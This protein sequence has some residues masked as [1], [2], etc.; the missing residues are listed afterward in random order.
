MNSL[1]APVLLPESDCL[2]VAVVIGRVVRPVSVLTLPS[3]D[4]VAT[5]DVS[6]PS[7]VGGRHES[8]PVC[9]VKP[10]ARVDQLA[11]DDVVVV[12]GRIRRRFFRAATGAVASR[13]ELAAESVT[14]VRPGSVGRTRTSRELDRVRTTLAAV[15]LAGREAHEGPASVSARPTR[16]RL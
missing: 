12:R 14:R 1:A 11:V 7:G 5:L 8:V 13:T 15:E 3:G 2:N 6:T 16:K 4:R 10:P 9:W